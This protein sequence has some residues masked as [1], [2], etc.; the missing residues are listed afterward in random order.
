MGRN[1]FASR[2]YDEA[3]RDRE[4]TKPTLEDV[5]GSPIASRE[6]PLAKLLVDELVVDDGS[7]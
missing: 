5:K 2:V 1:P 4:C 3:D 7:S 6:A